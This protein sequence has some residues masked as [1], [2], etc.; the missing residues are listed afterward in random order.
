MPNIKMINGAYADENVIY[1]VVNY[2]FDHDLEDYIST[3]L[4]VPGY[5]LSI[6]EDYRKQHL[7]NAIE[8]WKYILTVNMKNTGKRLLHF[9]IGLDDFLKKKKLVRMK[10]RFILEYLYE[11]A[12]Q[13]GFPSI[14]TMHITDEGNCH[15]HFVISA[16]NIYGDMYHVQ[17]IN[18]S[19]IAK[20]VGNELGEYIKVEYDN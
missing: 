17:D 11:Y 6:Y 20:F 13:K 19:S 7:R 18:A 5:L 1:D 3:Y 15:V 14:A 16:I 8:F 12:F 10:A 4:P 2:C 9:N